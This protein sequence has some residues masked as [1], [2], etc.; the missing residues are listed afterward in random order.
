[1]SF[2]MQ[3]LK[4]D[5]IS[6]MDDIYSI[7]SMDNKEFIHWLSDHQ[8]IFNIDKI[9]Y[10]PYCHSEMTI[11][12][13]EN[14]TDGAAWECHGRVRHR[15]CIREGSVLKYNNIG[16]LRLEILLFAAWALDLTPAQAKLIYPSLPSVDV[17]SSHF[18]IYRKLAESA[19]LFD[20]NQHPLGGPNRV[21]QIDETL[22]SKAKYNIGRALQQP[23]MWFFGGVDSLT[24]R[25]FI[26]YVKDRS[27]DTLLPIIQ[28][29]ILSNSIIHSDEWR[30]YRQLERHKYVHRTVNHKNNFVN[31]VNSVHTQMIEN[32][33]KYLKR[34]LRTRNV[35]RREYYNLYVHEWC[36]RR[37]LAQ[38]LNSFFRLIKVNL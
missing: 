10:C 22:V 18:H 30:A 20:L 37:N 7:F 15:L 4:Q 36:F 23:Q 25:V 11:K 5:F 16:N 34:W 32:V 38:N 1:M 26:D 12:Y 31:P 2:R 28:K 27:R 14:M 13:S 29:N 3:L 6:N 21:V 8:I 19:Y 24:G 33:W 35:T 17:I 9:F